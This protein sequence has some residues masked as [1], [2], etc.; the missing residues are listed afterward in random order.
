MGWELVGYMAVVRGVLWL[1]VALVGLGA[2]LGNRAWLA[3]FAR[4][5]WKWRAAS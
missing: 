1:S 3:D 5:Y 4:T 2:V